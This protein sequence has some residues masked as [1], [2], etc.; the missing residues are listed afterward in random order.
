[1]DR[2]VWANWSLRDQADFEGFNKEWLRWFPD[3]LVGQE[4]LMPMAQRRAGFRISIAVIAEA[5]AE[6]TPVAGTGARP[7]AR[8]AAKSAAVAPKKAAASKRK[9]PS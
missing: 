6:P 8:P 7:A 4:T 9:T 2:V 5:G 1:L 3:P